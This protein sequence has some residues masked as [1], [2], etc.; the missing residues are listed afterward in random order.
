AGPAGRRTERYP[1]IELR[2]EIGRDLDKT[3]AAALAVIL[4]PFHFANSL[5]AAAP[6][7]GEGKRHEPV[8]AQRADGAKAESVLGDAEQ[9][10]AV[11]RSELEV[12]QLVRL[13]AGKLLLRDFHT[14]PAQ[15]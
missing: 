8:R 15:F 13:F 14:K 6:I 1:L 9:H 5:Q 10:A 11:A 7:K 12:H 2:A 4:K 3:H